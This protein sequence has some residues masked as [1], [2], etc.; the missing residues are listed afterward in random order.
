MESI[1]LFK[2]FEYWTDQF[3]N[4]W[5][6][7]ILDYDD[8]SQRD[9]FKNLGWSGFSKQQMIIIMIV[10]VA[11]FV[12]LTSIKWFHQKNR[13]QPL[14]M[15]YNTFLKKLERKNIAPVNSSMGPND[16]KKHLSQLGVIRFQHLILLLDEYKQLRYREE[17]PNDSKLKSLVRRFKSVSIKK[18]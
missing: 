18:L 6:D 15:A 16:L 8:Q 5:N 17:A 11:L 10:V 12:L 13:K 14:T 2:Q 4:R 3:N 7:W 9:L 1:G